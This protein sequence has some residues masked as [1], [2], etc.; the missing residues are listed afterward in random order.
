[1]DPNELLNTLT[2]AVTGNATAIRVHTCLQPAGGSGD[3][4]FP[5]TYPTDDRDKP[6]VYA[7]EKRLIDGAEVDCVLLDSVQ[8]QANRLELALQQAID[9]GTLPLPIIET[10]VD[11][12]GRVTILQAPHRLY[13]AILRDSE[14]DGV[15]FWD[16]ALGRRLMAARP[17]KATALFEYCPQLLLLGGWHS[18]ARGGRGAKITRALTSEIIGLNTRPGERPASRIDPLGIERGAG[19]VY[20]AAD[21]GRPW[22]LNPDQAQVE[23]GKPVL[24]GDGKPSNIGHGNIRPSLTLGGVTVAEARQIA[25]LSLPA[26]RRLHFPTAADEPVSE[27]DQAARTALAL[28]A[29]TPAA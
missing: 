20:H 21:A 7:T 8:S 9:D 3:K 10:A 25:V 22:T 12:Y 23:K 26:L 15:R 11:G 24:Y 19:P 5:P 13:D 16:S 28:C 18:Q 6:V 1:M 17:E 2:A 4:I 27:R 29:L 14:L